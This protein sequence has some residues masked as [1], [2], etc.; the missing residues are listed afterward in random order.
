MVPAAAPQDTAAAGGGLP[1]CLWRRLK[2]L[3]CPLVVGLE[4]P[5]YEDGIL[6]LEETHV[7]CLS[8]QQR[9][10]RLS[11]KG[12]EWWGR[13]IEYCKEVG[14]EV[15]GDT[16]DSPAS[17][18]VLLRDLIGVAIRYQYEDA[19]ADGHLKIADTGISQHEQQQQKE[20]QQ[21]QHRDAANL[22]QLLH[23]PIAR[24]L[25]TLHLPPLASD[26]SPAYTLAA[27]QAIEA[28]V[29]PYHEASTNETTLNEK[30]TNALLQQ[31]PVMLGMP[32]GGSGGPQWREYEK[33]FVATLRVLHLAQLQQTQDSINEALER[34][35]LL[36]ADPRTDHRLA[37][38]G[39]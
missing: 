22:L 23:A 9:R 25:D 7:R 38:V 16:E 8:R 13:F 14:L 24:A 39:Y 27:L 31:L 15:A 19:T 30:E 4:S 36:T 33:E 21:E 20:Q 6:W 26:A 35:Q 32:L 37:K 11:S 34:M 29:K 12:K 28:R 10:D 17:R 3:R 5:L 1:G 18:L 2:V